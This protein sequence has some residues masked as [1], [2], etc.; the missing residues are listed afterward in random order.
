M[1]RPVD[2]AVLLERA[3]FLAAHSQ[4]QKADDDFARAYILGDRKPALLDTICYSEST[5]RRVVEE[6]AGA[7]APLLWA[8][9]GESLAKRQLWTEAAAAIGEGVRLQPEN[10]GYRQ[11]QILA[12]PGRRRPQRPAGADRHARPI[13]HDRSH[14][15]LHRRRV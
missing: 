7:A 1:A 11:N 14:D 9:R 3:S 2:T 4:G 6:S 12:L 10:L 13:P 8:N 15:G 5:F